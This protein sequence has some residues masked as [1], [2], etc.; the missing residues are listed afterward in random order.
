M[1]DLMELLPDAYKGSAEV[2][3]LQGAFGHWADALDAARDA[4][5]AQMFVQT[6]TFGL[7]NW[8]A[9]LGIETDETRNVDFR[10]ARVLSKLR[11]AGTTT[12]GMIQNVAESFSNGDV[13][14][15]EYNGESRFEVKF[16]GT[17]G[18][19]PNM[20]DLTDAIEEIKP[21]HLAYTYVFVYRTHAE[22]ARLTYGQMGAYT[23]DTL[24]EGALS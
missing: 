5:F 12:K 10:R 7:K 17:I 18:I 20:D 21:A 24:R 2:V 13:A 23:H 8:E 1:S 19:P 4:L 3:E 11:G 22:L 16:V 14:I 15:L 6:A 9:A